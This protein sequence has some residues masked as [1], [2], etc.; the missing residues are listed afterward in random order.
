VS[1]YP[2]QRRGGQGNLTLDVNEKSGQ[3]VAAKELLPGDELMVVTAGGAATRVA[4]NAVPEQGRATQGKRIIALP[5][6]DRVVEVARV[7][8][9]RGGPEGNEDEVPGVEEAPGEE[10]TRAAHDNGARPDDD[11]EQLALLGPPNDEE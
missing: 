6:G 4:A 11:D 9:E 8:K 7:A 3:L 1:D 10:A 5:E 2:V